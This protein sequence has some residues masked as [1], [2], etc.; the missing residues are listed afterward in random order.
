MSGQLRAKRQGRLPFRFV[1]HLPLDRERVATL[2]RN[3]QS[4]LFESFDRIAI[5]RGW[6]EH[7]IIFHAAQ[8]RVSA[9]R[10]SL[11][12][13]TVLH[14]PHQ[15]L[16]SLAELRH[17]STESAGTSFLLRHNRLNFLLCSGLTSAAHEAR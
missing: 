4:A 8:N 2:P 10:I 11:K 7:F 15:V 14:V 6:S 3:D 9:Q 1:F 17:H 5:R 16:F 13:V 12:L